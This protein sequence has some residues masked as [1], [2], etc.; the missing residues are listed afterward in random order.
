[1][2]YAVIMA[3]GAL[4][5][6][7]SNRGVAVFNDGFR[8]LVPQY[9]EGKI[10]RRELAAMSFA[11]SFGLVIG[12]AIPTSIAATIILIHCLLLSTDMIGTFCPVTAAGTILSAVI[13]AVYGLGVLV[14]LE[15][16]VNAF[17]LLPYNF[18][19]NLGQVSTPV[20]AGFAIFPAVAIGYQHGFKKAAITGVITILVWFIIKRVGIIP[21]ETYNITLSAEGLAMFS[22]MV[23]MLI[24]ASRVK[25]EGGAST[26]QLTAV[27]SKQVA[28]IQ[29]NWYFL[30]LMGGLV[31]AGT[32]LSI[33]AGDPISLNLLSKGEITSAAMAAFAR[34]IGFVPLVLTTAVVTG[35]YGAVGCTFIFTAGLLLTGKPLLAFIAGA[36]ILTAEV[37]LINFFAKIMDK[38]VGIREMGEH[39][40]TAMNKVLEVAL[41]FGSVFAAQA[42][43]A[44]IGPMFIIACYLLNKQSKKPI[45]DIAVGPVA[46]I[47]FGI[48]INIF[49][50][51]GLYALPAAK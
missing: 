7:L 18:L 48:I 23:M 44:G 8:P 9:F 12:F 50:V 20:I 51:L 42:M 27:F 43:V 1:M 36:A 21:M 37:F 16:I 30:A 2:K 4:A 19:S 33:L 10:S 3:I 40:R 49:V 22:G 41:L 47:A 14:G 35:V 5:S 25:A 45:V 13:G 11:I 29:K 17:A 26:A 24:F 15:A 6:V 28:R 31:A 39:I 38:F 32:S 46:A 34:A